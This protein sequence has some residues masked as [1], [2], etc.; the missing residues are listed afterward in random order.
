MLEFDKISQYVDESALK[1]QTDFFL[2]LFDKIEDKALEVAKSFKGLQ[3]KVE[4][5]SGLKDVIEAQK[6]LNTETATYTKTLKSAIEAQ[7]QEEKLSKAV[8]AAKQ[9]ES[10]AAEQLAKQQLA[11]TKL[12]E[13]NE[14]AAEKERIATEK[15][16]AAKQL[17]NQAEGNLAAREAAII[18]K[19]E[20]EKASIELAQSLEAQTKAQEELNAA[21][22]SGGANGNQRAQLRPVA[23]ISKE[24]AAAVVK[25]K[26]DLEKLTGTL[27][28]NEALQVIYKQELKEVN[29]ELK[30]LDKNTSAADKNTVGYKSKVQELTGRQNQLKKEITD[31]NVTVRNQVKE[32][33]AA[34]GSL[35]AL[36]A[37]LNLA[38]REYDKLSAAAKA[39]PLGL[40]LKR[41]VDG[42]TAS[43]K[44][45]EEATGRFQRNVGNYGGALV[46]FFG[47]AFS[48]LRQI[49]YIVPGLGIAG[50]IG[51]IVSGL[52]A[53]VGG[54][55]NSSKAFNV[56][57]ESAKA[58]TEALKE[59]NKKQIE[60]SAGDITKLELY[61]NILNDATRSQKERNEAL[62]AYN[63][64]ADD[65]NKIDKTQLDNITLV[66]DKISQQI[67]LI[68]KRAFSRAAEAVLAEKAEALLLAKEDARLK[69]EKSY[70]ADLEAGHILT[71]KTFDV[72]TKKFVDATDLQL[73]LDEKRIIS[74]RI[75][76]DA[77]VRQ[78]QV[79][80]DASKKALYGLIQLEGFKADQKS[81]KDPKTKKER[82][83][84]AD[85]FKEQEEERKARFEALKLQL[86]DRI[87]TD[88][89]IVDDESKSYDERF[90]AAQ[91]FYDDTLKLAEASQ[92][93]GLESI[94][95]KR[96]EDK[97][98]AN[99]EIKDKVELQKQLQAIDKSAAQQVVAEN[100]KYNSD[101]LKGEKENEK[102]IKDLRKSQAADRLAHN[103]SVHEQEMQDIQNGYDEAL[104]ALDRKHLKEKKK[105]RNNKDELDK[106]E[107]QYNADKLRL[108]V[109]FQ[110]AL[111]LEDIK[112]T[113]ET[114][115]LAETRAK[116]SGKQ[117]DL[118]A[119][120]KAKNDLATLELKLQKTITDYQIKSNEEQG[121][122]DDELAA[123]R[124]AH[125]EKL[126]GY[127]KQVFD[128][129]AGF[130][131]IGVDKQLNGV[132]DQIDALDKQKEKE[133]EVANSSITNAQDRANAISA[134]E[135]TSQAKRESLERRQRQLQIEKARFEK[136]A[137]I[138]SLILETTLAV[139]RALSDRTFPYPVRV[140]NAITA[141]VLG[142]AQ[143]AK[144]IATPI[145][146]F[147]SGLNKD[148]EGFGV[149]GDGGKHEV[150]ERKDGSLEITPDTDTLTYVNKGDRIHPDA[151]AY[152]MKYYQSIALGSMGRKARRLTAAPDVRTQ[153]SDM[154]ILAEQAKTNRW[155]EKLSKKKEVHLNASESGL[156]ALW[157]FGAN[158][159]KY[160]NEQTNW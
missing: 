158:T 90:A 18:A 53:L 120:A 11:E 31:L 45:Q 6:K 73:E 133:I 36:R 57:K 25:Y 2:G 99:L 48:F 22:A 40:G 35:E 121:K 89:A 136:A 122:S 69:A 70:K 38:T 47:K 87:N 13:A 44:T 50:I 95:A 33:N 24:D 129:I 41:E 126:A 144:A 155:L 146:K 59:A 160:V 109:N 51:A 32:Q 27:N 139:L 80:F 4:G 116:A 137:A 29:A 17:E 131:A 106:A 1:A 135:A 78:K 26:D 94:E 85:L 118:D 63:H 12:R 77:V 83:N 143:I 97:R 138:A 110:E 76:T 111:L 145:P 149:T 15:A 72:L 112:F 75:A 42:L 81:D 159:V 132:Q 154:L 150:I 14:R 60:G 140:V 55:F 52:G 151:D 156:T 91:A 127:A 147:K 58:Y 128:L 7:I 88:K 43:I 142:A 54:L 62:N 8:A 108:Q 157:K 134:I 92:S 39:S 102:Q 101:V 119:V 93:F 107:R 71:A 3:I 104:L 100:A 30:S 20:E 79:E 153:S 113:K 152:I 141:G 130:A 105:L 10:K 74:G 98:K 67:D 16:T 5:G 37:R 117:E 65:A 64:I 9:A 82:D 61:R 103:K 66:N 148:Y 86:Q 21:I 46:G 84:L 23:P 124:L 49:A 123:K 96:V 28:E 68:E 56:A 34:A 125:L 114:I 19:Q 115:A